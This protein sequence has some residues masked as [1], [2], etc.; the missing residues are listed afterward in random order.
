MRV[1]FER[2]AQRR[3]RRRARRH[4][5]GTAEERVCRALSEEADPRAPRRRRPA[6]WNNRPP[7][8]LP[9]FAA[10]THESTVIPLVEDSL[11]IE[12]D[13]APHGHGSI[14]W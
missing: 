10:K 5:S 7:T 14:F 1:S 12:G 2:R 6:M 11:G 9:R 8:S 3:R 13:A 4:A